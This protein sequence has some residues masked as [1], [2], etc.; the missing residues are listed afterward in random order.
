MLDVLGHMLHGGRVT[1]GILG[2]L[3]VDLAGSINSSLVRQSDG[4]MRRFT[5]SG[6]ANDIASLATRVVVVMRH[7]ARKFQPRVD[8]VTSPG[9]FVNGRP[10]AASGLPGDGTSAIVTDRGVFEIEQGGLRVRSLHSGEELGALVAD[11]PV[12]LLVE[13]PPETEPPTPQE[14]R[15]LREEIDQ[16]GWYTS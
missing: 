9:K 12:P 8:F 14:L 6:G 1:T 2:A 15:I 13:S 7:D 16:F 11:T 3:Q 10:R 5:G 4:T